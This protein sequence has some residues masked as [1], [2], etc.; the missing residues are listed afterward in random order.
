M[1]VGDALA[2]SVVRHTLRA[3]VRSTWRGLG[4]QR[5]DVDCHERGRVDGSDERLEYTGYERRVEPHD[6]DE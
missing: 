5:Y 3:R 6:D 1:M 2:P 4:E